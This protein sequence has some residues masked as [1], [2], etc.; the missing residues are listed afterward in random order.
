M[1]QPPVTA[2]KLSVS[3]HAEFPKAANL[4]GLIFR[5]KPTSNDPLSFLQHNQKCL[6]KCNG[7]SQGPIYMSN[8]AGLS[9]QSQKCGMWEKTTN[10]GRKPMQLSI[11]QQ[12]PARRPADAGRAP[13]SS[14]SASLSAEKC[15]SVSGI[16]TRCSLNHGCIN[17]FQASF[18]VCREAKMP[19]SRGAKDIP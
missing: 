14:G 19:G 17:T 15:L 6:L 1:L 7:Q 10:Q 3:E 9:L 18:F 13:G 11:P 12:T 2:A 8:E 4:Q 5:K 16:N